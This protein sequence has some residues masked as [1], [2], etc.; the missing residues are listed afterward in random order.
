[1]VCLYHIYR[2]PAGNYLGIEGII[3]IPAGLLFFVSIFKDQ[4]TGIIPLVWD[5]YNLFHGRPLFWTLVGV[6]VWARLAS[7]DL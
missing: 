3:T 5:W 4:T 2:R 7:N 6:L 1:M